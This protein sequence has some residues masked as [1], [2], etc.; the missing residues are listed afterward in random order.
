MVEIDGLLVPFF[1]AE[2]DITGD[3]EL[4][5]AVEDVNTPEKAERLTGKSVYIKKSLIV[6]TSGDYLPGQIYGF[7][8]ID[9]HS[10]T[11]GR[12][13]GIDDIPGNPLL[14]LEHQ[15]REILIPLHEDLIAEINTA[16]KIVR[17]NLPEGFLKL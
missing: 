4:T 6:F 16:E 13:T 2:W 14:R 11:L 5:I 12:I 3:Y 17:V 8:V 15:G 7:L 10:G 1:I 9:N